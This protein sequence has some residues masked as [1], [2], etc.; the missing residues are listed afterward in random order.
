MWADV[1]RA[2]DSFARFTLAPIAIASSGNSGGGDDDD[3][4]TG[5]PDHTPY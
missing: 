3:D 1:L 5:A 2:C 4:G